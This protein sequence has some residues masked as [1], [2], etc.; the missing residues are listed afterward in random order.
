MRRPPW[1]PSSGCPTACRRECRRCR[2]TRAMS[3]GATYRRP[4]RCAFGSRALSA[5]PRPAEPGRSESLS[6]AGRPDPRDPTRG[7]RRRDHLHRFVRG[8]DHRCGHRFGNARDVH[9]RRSLGVAELRRVGAGDHVADPH[10]LL[11]DVNHSFRGRRGALVL[12]QEADGAVPWPIPRQA[13][14]PDHDLPPPPD[15]G[16]EPHRIPLQ[17]EGLG[18]LD[19]LKSIAALRAPVLLHHDLQLGVG[20]SVTEED[21][22]EWLGHRTL[23]SLLSP[24]PY[25]SR[26]RA[27]SIRSRAIVRTFCPAMNRASVRSSTSASAAIFRLSA[28]PSCASCFS[29]TL[30]AMSRIMRMAKHDPQLPDDDFYAPRD[31]NERMPDR[32]RPASPATLRKT[33]RPED[34]ADEVTAQ[35]AEN[36][37]A[38]EVP[39]RAEGPVRRMLQ[40]LR[41]RR[42]GD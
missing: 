16:F 5:T 21:L 24:F 38:A 31:Y 23:P 11:A 33:L 12:V 35:R 2:A 37:I 15:H 32:R 30:V 8:R 3:M 22:S 13:T 10:G 34:L 39:S 42:L 4:S 27:R 25:P 6:V 26:S 41:R 9:V 40:R 29:S 19:D 14:L 7:L 36:R 18:D 20:G 28:R 17:P 1:P